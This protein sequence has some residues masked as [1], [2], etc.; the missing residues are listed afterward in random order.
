MV[1]SCPGK[2]KKITP[3][4]TFACCLLSESKC[5]E[6]WDVSPFPVASVCASPVTNSA[7]LFVTPLTVQHHPLSMGFPRQEYWCGL[8]FLSP[9]DL[10][11]PGIQASSPALAGEFFTTEPP[12]KPAVAPRKQQ[13]QPSAIEVTWSQ[14]FGDGWSAVF[15]DLSLIFSFCS[16]LAWRIPGAGEPGGLPSM[17]SHRVRHDWSDLAAAAC[18]KNTRCVWEV[19]KKLGYRNCW[20]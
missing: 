2:R 1:D 11:D 4:D 5:N 8:P 18:L 3:A 14:D 6:I 16:V 17:G 12:G 19:E 10:P 13:I 9:G 15:P 7:W 20:R